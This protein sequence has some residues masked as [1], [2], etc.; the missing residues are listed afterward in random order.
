MKARLRRFIAEHELLFPPKRA[1]LGLSGGVDS[2]VLCRLL[3]E[4]GV[5]LHAVHVNYQLRGAAADEDEAFVRELCQ[6]LQVP[7]TVRRRPIEAAAE[8][9]GASVQAAAR[10]VRYEVFEQVAREYDFSCVALGH[11]LDD[12]VETVL[13]H[14]LR[15]TGLRGVA[16]M[17]IRRPIVEHSTIEIVRPLM[18]AR[19]SEIVS[20]A[21]EQDWEWRVDRSNRSGKYLRTALRKDVL[22]PLEQHAGSGGIE[23]IARTARL[24]RELWTQELGPRLEADLERCIEEESDHTIKVSLEPLL[25]ASRIWQQEMLLAVVRRYMPEAPVSETAAKELADLADAQVGR[26]KTYGTFTVWRER[27]HLVVVRRSDGHA[28]FERPLNP[29]ETVEL[30][31]GERL[32]VRYLDEVPPD[33]LAAGDRTVWL[34]ADRIEWPLR[35]RTWRD[36]DRFRPLGMDGHKNVS[37]LLT[38][39]KVPPHERNGVCVVVSNDRI[40]WVVGF[41]LS[42]DVRLRSETERAVELS[43]HS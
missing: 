34:D 30:P 16:G 41:R 36:G 40:V 28:A 23:N 26:R 12:Q 2:V 32:A 31:A 10:R 18:F 11:Q 35:V 39:A 38:E 5:N 29:G 17:P 9:E 13:L 25:N 19:R 24:V 14:L 7:L 43:V 42:H 37:D 15:G 27:E 21:R 6:T 1:A 33:P 4:L 8:E 3:S 22:P 20:F